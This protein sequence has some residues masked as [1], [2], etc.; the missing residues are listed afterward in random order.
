MDIRAVYNLAFA[1]TTFKSDRFYDAIRAVEALAD[2]LIMELPPEASVIFTEI[3]T[4][5][6]AWGDECYARLM[7]LAQ[8]RWIGAQGLG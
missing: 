2:D 3:L 6:S 4:H 7:R 8:A 1:L 5:G